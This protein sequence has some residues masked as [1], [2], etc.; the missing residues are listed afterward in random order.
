MARLAEAL[1]RFDS[2]WS[3]YG[4]SLTSSFR[5]HYGTGVGLA[6]NRKEYQVYLLGGKCDR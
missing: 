5:P 1:G 6:S 4:F 2:R 3:H